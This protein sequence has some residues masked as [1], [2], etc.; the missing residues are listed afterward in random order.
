[1]TTPA[2]AFLVCFVLGLVLVGRIACVVH[3]RQAD[4]AAGRAK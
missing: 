4:V 2:K 1:M 3:E